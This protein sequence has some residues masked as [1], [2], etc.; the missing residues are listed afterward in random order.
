M[1]KLRISQKEY[2]RSN[3]KLRSKKSKQ[4]KKTPKRKVGNEHKPT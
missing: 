4:N 3:Y 2:I 1:F